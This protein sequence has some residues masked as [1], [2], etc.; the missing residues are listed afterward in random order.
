MAR[1]PN[2]LIEYALKKS[3]C[4]DDVRVLKKQVF[5]LED[6]NGTDA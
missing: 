1:V 3:L 4:A 6:E 5:E 2:V